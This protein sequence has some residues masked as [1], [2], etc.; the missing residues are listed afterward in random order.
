MGEKNFIS[1]VES[2]QNDIPN[3]IFNLEDKK[4]QGIVEEIKDNTFHNPSPERSKQNEELHTDFDNNNS[5]TRSHVEETPHEGKNDD[6]EI[7]VK[8]DEELKEGTNENIGHQEKN[9][10]SKLQ[11]QLVPNPPNNDFNVLILFV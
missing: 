6:A 10:V 7:I 4:N 11:M 2:D 8:E 1:V 3:E 5:H 9:F